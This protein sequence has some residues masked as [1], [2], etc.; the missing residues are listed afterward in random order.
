[1][2]VAKIKVTVKLISIFVF[3]CN[4]EADQRL[5]F[6]ICKKPVFS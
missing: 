5:C 1:M 2:Y 3:A 6:G 4:R